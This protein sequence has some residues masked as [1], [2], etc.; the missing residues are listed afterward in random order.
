MLLE[1]V[2][3]GAPV[4][5]SHLLTAVAILGSILGGLW[6]FRVLQSG[7]SWLGGCLLLLTVSATAYVGISAAARN[8][9]SIQ[10]KI[11]VKQLAQSD[12]ASL[13]AD[14]DSLKAEVALECKKVGSQCKAKTKLLETAWEAVG[15]A[16]AHRDALGPV[17]DYSNAAQTL[18][19]F[20][21]L[22]SEA[23]DRW[24][25]LAMPFLLVL[26]SELGTICFWHLAITHGGA[27]VEPRLEPNVIEW[28]SEFQRR[29]NRKPQL[30]E[31]QQAFP[32]IPRTTLWRRMKAA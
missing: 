30:P 31:V 21:G 24:L 13:R 10:T 9:S 1:D 5:P 3:K 29:N 11:Q 26:V 27:R 7:Q 23:V 16:E 2:F 20:T 32:E 17:T 4:T 18:S 25:T 14:H 8:A 12:V 28:V 22:P 6:G 19:A 15:T